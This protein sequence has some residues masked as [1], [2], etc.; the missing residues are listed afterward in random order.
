MAYINAEQTKAIRDTLKETFPK[1]RFGCRKRD[2][3]SVHITVKK[4]ELDWSNLFTDL[5]VTYLGEKYVLSLASMEAYRPKTH[6][7]L[8][9]WMAENPDKWEEHWEDKDRINIFFTKEQQEFIEKINEISKTAPFLKG[10]GELWFDKS[11]SMTD[12]FH[13]AWYVWIR[14]DETLNP[15]LKE[16]VKT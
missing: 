4:S 11:D 12:Y 2:Y 15:L 9:D 5:D 8:R 13:I 7:I 14:V 6:R 10:V 16:V 1:D 3:S